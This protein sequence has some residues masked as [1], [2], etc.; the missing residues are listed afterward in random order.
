MPVYHRQLNS[1]H[2]KSAPV[3]VITCINHKLA[4]SFPIYRDRV[5]LYHLGLANSTRGAVISGVFLLRCRRRKKPKPPI[6]A[7]PPTAPPTPAP[8][9]PPA[10]RPEDGSVCPVWVC[11]VSVCD[12]SV[13]DVSVGDVSVGDVSVGDVSVGDDL[14]GVVVADAAVVIVVVAVPISSKKFSLRVTALFFPQQLVVLPQH[15]VLE[16]LVPSQGVIR[17]KGSSTSPP[18]LP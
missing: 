3:L 9:F 1:G 6:I 15:H 11:A 8:A 4:Y 5:N 18:W 12:V 10:E 17:A 13:G 2:W 16:P 14:D 7:I